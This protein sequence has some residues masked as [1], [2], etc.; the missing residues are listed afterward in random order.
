[1]A[2]QEIF[3]NF[4]NFKTDF[5]SICGMMALKIFQNLRNYRYES[6]G[7]NGTARQMIGGDTPPPPNGRLRLQTFVETTVLQFFKSQGR[8]NYSSLFENESV[9]LRI[10]LFTERGMKQK[11]IS[12]TIA[13]I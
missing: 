1:M 12:L 7:H 2:F 9:I 13:C 8:T 10:N 11:F 4:L 6:F 3:H 5:H